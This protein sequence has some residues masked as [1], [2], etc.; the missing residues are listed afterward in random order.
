M[1]TIGHSSASAAADNAKAASDNMDDGIVAAI[2]E[3]VTVKRAFLE[4]TR[5]ATAAKRRKLD[6]MRSQTGEKKSGI[7]KNGD[8]NVVHGGKRE[9]LNPVP[10]SEEI[11]GER[12]RWRARGLAQRVHA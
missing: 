1:A 3:G 10:C 7:R 12:A 5:K 2:E 8:W 11:A 4:E 9:T 6:E